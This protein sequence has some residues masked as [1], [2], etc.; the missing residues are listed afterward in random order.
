MSERKSLDSMENKTVKKLRL[1]TGKWD[2][3]A[4]ANARILDLTRQ[5]SF[6]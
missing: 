2:A 3:D 4:S 1:K 5:L 6:R